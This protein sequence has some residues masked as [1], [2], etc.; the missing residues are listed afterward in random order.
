MLTVNIC[1][2]L[3]DHQMFLSTPSHLI[4][5]TTL[6]SRQDRWYYFFNL[7]FI[8]FQR[9]E[10]RSGE[11]KRLAQ[12]QRGGRVIIAKVQGTLTGPDAALRM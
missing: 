9:R 7:L 5:K 12:A 10:L 8:F 11:V 6:G 1:R 3:T 4:I 2:A